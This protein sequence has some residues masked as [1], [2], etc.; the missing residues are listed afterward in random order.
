M[1]TWI[2]MGGTFTIPPF[3]RQGAISVQMMPTIFNRRYAITMLD[4]RDNTFAVSRALRA[5]RS[6]LEKYELMELI[7]ESRFYPT[8]RHAAAA[9]SQDPNTP[10]VPGTFMAPLFALPYRAHLCGLG[11]LGNIEKPTL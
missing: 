10:P 1:T 5:F 8:N 11:V 6:W 3:L 4:E 2:L 9:F 7:D